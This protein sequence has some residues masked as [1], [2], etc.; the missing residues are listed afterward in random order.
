MWFGLPLV[1]SIDDSFSLIS[2]RR[3]F[4]IGWTL[5]VDRNINTEAL[6]FDTVSQRSESE[7]IYWNRERESLHF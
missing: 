5:F 4:V 7:S 2:Y 1:F 6:E 3:E